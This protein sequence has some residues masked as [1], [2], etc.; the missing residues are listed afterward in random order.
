MAVPTLDELHKPVLEIASF[1]PNPLTRKQFF[2]Q[3]TTLFSLTEADLHEM[4]PS[5]AQTRIENRTN[6]AM[7]DLKR[8]GLINNLQRNQWQITPQG[9]DYLANHQGIIKFVELRKLWPESPGDSELPATNIVDSVE[10]TPNEQMGKSYR[11][12][13]SQLTDEI[14]DS[15]KGVSPTSFERL[16][17]RLLNQMGYGEID[18]ETGHSGDQGIDGILN[19]DTLGLEKS[20]CRQSG[21]MTPTGSASRIFVISPAAS[22]VKV[23]QGG[24]SLQLRPSHRPQGRPRKISRWA[25]SQLF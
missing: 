13:Q 11:E 14:L 10:N 1:A 15:V 20:M 8:A 23:Q 5:G 9:Q 25:T 6:W 22:T 21:M 7:T 2:E 18:R 12:L 3:L 17:N 16:V 24:C 19:Q 4:V